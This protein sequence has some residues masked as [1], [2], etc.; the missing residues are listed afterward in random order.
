MAFDL[1]PFL[2]EFDLC[3]RQR[4][5]HRRRLCE[6]AA[7]PLLAW[8]RPGHDPPT[9]LSA[10]MHG[11]E[12]AGTL[13]SLELLKLGV[14]DHGSW[15]LCPALNPTGL[16]AGTRDTAE[17]I[18]PNRDY[19]HRRCPIVRAHADWLASIPCPSLFLSLHEDWEYA[20]FYFYEINLGPDRPDRADAIVR[21]VTPWLPPETSPLIDGHAVRSTGWIYH[22]AEADLPEEWPEAI[23]L[24]KRGCPLSFTY[25]TPSSQPLDIRVAAHLAAVR[26]AVT[27]A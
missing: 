21:A 24:A 16:A 18:D 15:L 14:F 7:G 20:G 25:E 8:E 10:G 11:D 4:G 19:L 2:D 22:P 5:F 26:A 3:A 12:P 6:T 27:P 9:Y 23:F 13:A 17:G 1:H